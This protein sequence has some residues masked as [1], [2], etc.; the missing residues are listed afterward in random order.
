MWHNSPEKIARD[1][2]RDME[3]SANGWTILRFT[4]KELNDQSNEVAQVIMQA[5]RQLSNPGTDGS[6]KTVL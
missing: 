1:K 2:R 5:I 3:L 4:D 6:G